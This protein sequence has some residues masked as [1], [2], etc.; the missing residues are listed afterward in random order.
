MTW[1]Y[2]I[3]IF[4]SIIS[5]ICILYIIWKPNILKKVLN[6]I[7]E[8]EY[9]L[10]EYGVELE[11]YTLYH[12]ENN[13]KLLV[14]FN[15]GA[16]IY[17]NRKNT[18]GLLNELSTLLKEYDILTFDYPVRFDFTI[19]ETMLNINETL[20]KF[21]NYESYYGLSESAGSLLLGTFC[22]KESNLD[23]SKKIEIP[24]IGINFKCFIGITGVF[25][26]DF[27]NRILNNLFKI[28]IMRNTPNLKLYSAFNLN[29]PRLIISNKYDFLFTQT[30]NFLQNQP[31]S[32]KIFENEL[33]PHTFI[34][35]NIYKET[36]ESI[37]LIFNFLKGL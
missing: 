8:Y 25:S 37:Q 18:Y 21:L 15:G 26:I 30:E 7:P 1:L 22:L 34:F 16:F 5:T 24:Q 29:I 36:S 9:D 11:N 31:S 33:L 2:I 10:N 17:S 35:S 4:I 12:R 27:N 32:Y 13:K 23:F 20:K 28:Y 3:Q 14:F 19:K 6:V